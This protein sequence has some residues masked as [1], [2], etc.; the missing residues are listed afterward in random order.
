MR[1]FDAPDGRRRDAGRA[2]RAAVERVLD[3]CLAHARPRCTSSSSG[4]TTRLAEL[5][6][7]RRASG[8]WCCPSSSKCEARGL[9]P[10]EPVQER[11]NVRQPGPFA[12]SP[13]GQGQAEARPSFWLEG[14]PSDAV[15]TVA[16][17]QDRHATD[18]SRSW[19]KAG[20]APRKHPHP[21]RPPGGNGRRVVRRAQR[22]DLIGG[23]AARA[24][25]VPG[26]RR[27]P[28]LG[29][30][31]GGP[32]DRHR[33]A[34]RWSAA[35][36]RSCRRCW[37][38][39][40]ALASSCA[41]RSRACARCALGAIVCLATLVAGALDHRH[42]RRRAPR[43]PRSARTP[44]SRSSGLVGPIGVSILVA[45]GLAGGVVLVTGASVGVLM[46]SSGQHVA[47]AAGAGARLVRARSAAVPRASRRRPTWARCRAG[48]RAPSPSTP[49]DGAH[50]FADLF[51]EVPELDE[52]PEPARAPRSRARAGAARAAA[53]EDAARRA[54]T[55]GAGSQ[56]PLPAP[57]PQAATGCRPRSL[58]RS[59]ASRRRAAQDHEKIARQLVE[60]LA[61]FG[62][63]ARVI[64][65]V[66]GPRVTR[67]ELQLAPG[68]KVSRVS[69][70]RDDL[71]YALAT[72]EIR[73]LAPIPGKQ[74]VGVE[75]PNLSANLV[76][77]GD[78]Y[79]EP[80]A[81]SSP[82]TAWLGKDISGARRRLRPGP[83]AAPADRRHHRL[84]QVGLHQRDPVLDPAAGDARRRAH[85]PGRPQ[86]GRAEP[87]RGDP[88]PADA[89]RHEHEERLARAA[90]RRARD[91]DAATR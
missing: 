5:V 88:A 57:R 22:T 78:I 29:R 86:A 11:L 70:L 73:I 3:E 74:A 17:G 54:D 52:A 35:R 81:G 25:R 34:P 83:D 49:L 38:S 42:R 79:A 36:R 44:A 64:G 28:G 8:R 10:D 68:I 41:A 67:Y 90:E 20:S 62:V 77:L 89:G 46:R 4:C 24:G 45:L 31:R 87:L 37:W 47:R 72:T 27:V 2:A 85:D 16:N 43:R 9:P 1:G 32:Q 23:G 69:Q 39:L 15:D 7:R 75:V 40:G 18:P 91:G 13:H 51:G 59:A 58:K 53:D 33:A 26:L 61:N 71:A 65:M 50:A 66:T 6:S 19:S 55:A 48:R 82:L 60:A 21:P 63:E 84:G 12:T 80:P 76:T 14:T 30:G 56:L